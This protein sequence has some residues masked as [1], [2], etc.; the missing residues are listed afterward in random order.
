MAHL[1]VVLVHNFYL[2]AD[3][4]LKTHQVSLNNEHHDHRGITITLYVGQMKMVK[5]NVKIRR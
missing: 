1:S 2:L 4:R 3:V 5:Y